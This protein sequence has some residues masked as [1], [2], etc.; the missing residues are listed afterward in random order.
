MSDKRSSFHFQ[1]NRS[2]YVVIRAK[3]KLRSKPQADTLK[4]ML[5]QRHVLRIAFNNSHIKKA[6]A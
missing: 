5:S 4:K 2:Y 6:K 3:K 1:L